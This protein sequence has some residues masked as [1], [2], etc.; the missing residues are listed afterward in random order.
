MDDF[1]IYDDELYHYGRKGM[2]WGQ[3]IFGK[4]KSG[5][6][7]VGQK[8]KAAHEKHK[9]KSAEKK[10]AE[11]ERKTKEVQAKRA[12]IMNSRKLSNDELNE[13]IKRLT[14]EKEYQTLLRDTST[15]SKGQTMAMKILENSIN[16]IGQQTI[17]YLMGQGV[18]KMAYRFF[19]ENIV[20]PKKGQKDK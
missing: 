20:N 12:K 14:L 6:K 19:E 10:A 16:N 11:A 2:K 5:A 8:A 7:V 9:V 4:V 13:R 1:I 17:T 3:H 15:I 18:N